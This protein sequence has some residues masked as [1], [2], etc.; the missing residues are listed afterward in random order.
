VTWRRRLRYYLTQ[1]PVTLVVIAIVVFIGLGVWLAMSIDLPKDTGKSWPLVLFRL[2]RRG[3]TT[4]FELTGWGGVVLILLGW[5][6][7]RIGRKGSD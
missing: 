4:A 2:R 7:T 1:E 3:D 5:A 6:L